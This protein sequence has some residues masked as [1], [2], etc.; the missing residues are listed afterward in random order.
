MP[1]VQL[2]FDGQVA[3][4]TGAGGGLG[5]AHALELARRGA[6][7]VVNDVGGATDGA[8]SSALPAQRVA[9]EITAAGGV[10]IASTDTVA[11]PEGGASIVATAVE[12]F[13]TVHV[14][15]NNAGILRD[16]TI[17]KLTAHDLQQV[18]A[19]HVAGAFHVTQPAWELMREQNHGRIINTSSGSGLFGN[20]GQANY[21]TAKMGLVGLTRALSLEGRKHNIKVN[22]IV[23]VAATRMTERLLGEAEAARLAP[24]QVA[25]LVAYLAHGDCA[26]TGEV[27]SVGAGRVARVLIGITAGYRGDELSAE[28]VRDHFE[29]IQRSDRF[30]L[31]RNVVE[32]MREMLGAPAR[33]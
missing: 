16:G 4:V 26:A 12:A 31:P 23:P 29:D 22:A 15:V 9:D 14:V 2:N 6:R 11:T 17:R 32:E 30:V 28:S 3:V 20:F 10:A 7:V 27:Y 33:R 25:P 8:G 18:L 5:R 24:E 19:V 13:G 1:V 21:A